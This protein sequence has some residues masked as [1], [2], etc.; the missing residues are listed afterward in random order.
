MAPTSVSGAPPA[1]MRAPRGGARRALRGAAPARVGEGEAPAHGIV[2]HEGHAVRREDRERQARA[3]RHDHV[4][5]PD[6]AGALRGD[7]VRA[8]HLAQE[9]RGPPVDVALREHA[10]RARVERRAG[11]ARR[12]HAGEMARREQVG[13]PRFAETGR[14][15]VARLCGGR[16][17]LGH[18]RHCLTAPGRARRRL[19]RE[20]AVEAPSRLN[21][22]ACRRRKAGTSRSSSSAPVGLGAHLGDA[23]APVLGAA[24]RRRADPSASRRPCPGPAASLRSVKPVAITVMRTSSCEASGR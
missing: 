15:Q 2:E 6:E 9:R 3:I 11:V 8:V 16:I 18:A 21:Q 22:S 19:I 7:D 1:A 4:R 13:E 10:E 14:R 24:G 17:E 5:L 20:G 23:A 12:G